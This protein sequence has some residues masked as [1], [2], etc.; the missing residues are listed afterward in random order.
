MFSSR[1]LFKFLL[2]T[3]VVARALPSF[4]AL[5]NKSTATITASASWQDTPI[6]AS[7]PEVSVR[8]APLPPTPTF[9]RTHKY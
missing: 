5:V 7:E 9:Y 3:A 8:A 4:C 1:V 2:E 6:F